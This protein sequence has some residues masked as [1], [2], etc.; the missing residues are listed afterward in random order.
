MP[1][2]CLA[3]SILPTKFGDFVTHVFLEVRPDGSEREHVALVYG[4][5]AGLDDVA[6]KRLV[7]AALRADPVEILSS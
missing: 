3:T 5:V 2:R 7:A 6:I 4:D 1:A